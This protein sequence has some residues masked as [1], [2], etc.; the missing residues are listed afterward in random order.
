MMGEYFL[1]RI[2]FMVPTFIGITLITF[3][4]INLAPGGPIEQMLSQIRFGAGAA[5]TAVGGRLGAAGEEGVNEEILAELRRQ[6]GFDK[7]L[8]TRYGLWLWNLARL[9]F[10]FSFVYD[11]PVI[12]VIVGKFPVSL[13]FGVISFVVTYLVCIPLGIAKAVANGSAFDGLSSVLVFAGYSISPLMLGILLIVLFGGGSFLDWFPISGLTSDFYDEMGFWWKV[14]DRAHHFVL[15]LLC[16]LIGNF[17]TLTLLMKNSVLEEIGR[18][19]VIT[20]RAKGLERRVVFFRHVLRNALIPVA[21]GLG[22][23]LGVFFVGNLFIEQIF[24]LDGMGLLFY[25]SL[26]ARDYPVLL[27]L[28]SLVSII[29]MVGN[30]LSDFLY[31]VIDPRI[32]FAK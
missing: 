6:F 18:D 17:A 12:A 15:P 20:A 19:Y 10:G 30:L 31:V 9:D 7:P 32:D 27:G 4:I 29:L 16:Y 26:L 23:F 11:E 21:T 1:K 5:E 14:G 22:G 13:P 2:L 24:S 8:L 25:N 28:L 3:V